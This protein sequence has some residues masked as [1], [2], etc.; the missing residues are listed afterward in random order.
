MVLP[1]TVWLLITQKPVSESRSVMSDSL[2]LHGLYSSWNFPGQNTGVGSRSL[3]QGIFSTQG[4]NPGLQHW[5]RILYQ[6]SHQGS[7]GE[8]NVG[9]TNIDRKESCFNQNASNLGRRQTLAPPKTTFW[10]KFC[11]VMKVFK[12][13]RG[14]ILV[15]HWDWDSNSTIFHCEQVCWLL[16]I[17][18]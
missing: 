12:G 4:L 18:I 7:T 11:S 1:S 3:L 10:T 17:F 9:E 5:R 15:N 2:R 16:E 8:T 14:I 6:L 13:K